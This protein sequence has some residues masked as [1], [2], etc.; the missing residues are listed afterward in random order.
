MGENHFKA[1]PTALY[2]IVLLMAAIAYHLLQQS[3]I[4]T[5]GEVSILKDAIRRDWKGKLSPVLYLF[6]V[7]AT[8]RSSLDRPS[9]SGDRRTHLANSGSAHRKTSCRVWQAS[10]WTPVTQVAPKGGKGL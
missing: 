1:V 10:D 7:F 8:L 9:G 6:A 2:G 5:Q 3:I 4:R